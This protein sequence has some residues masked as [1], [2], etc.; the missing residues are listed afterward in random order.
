MFGIF[1][2]TEYEALKLYDEYLNGE[3]DIDVMGI[4]F[5]SSEILKELDPTAY[6]CG[7]ADFCDTENIEIE[8]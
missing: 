5:T 7:F 8:D 3:G 1:K 2:M 6:N 4:S